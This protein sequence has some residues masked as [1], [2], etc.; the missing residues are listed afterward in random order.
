MSDGI[1]D[2][3]NFGLACH[4]WALSHDLRKVSNDFPASSRLVQSYSKKLQFISD[5]IFCISLALTRHS[6]EDEDEDEDFVYF[7]IDVQK[8]LHK[9]HKLVK[10]I[11]TFYRALKLSGNGIVGN[12]ALNALTLDAMEFVEGAISDLETIVPNSPEN[13]S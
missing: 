13:K 10:N 3:R 7:L 2:V 11:D 8:L 4:I 5:G 6:L 12:L 9:C 1:D